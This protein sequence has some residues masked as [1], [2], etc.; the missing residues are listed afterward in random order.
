[1]PPDADRAA[2]AAA[3]ETKS[4]GAGKKRLK[5]LG[6]ILGV[7]LAEGVGIFVLVGV[8][9]APPPATDAAELGQNPEEIIESMDVELALVECDAIN[10]KSGQ[11]VI[12]HIVLCARVAAADRQR[13]GKLI[14]LRQSTIKDRVQMIL[15]SADPQ[16]LNEPNLDTIKRQIK[17][18]VDK[19][20]DDEKL[21]HEILIPQFLQSRSTV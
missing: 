20:L 7:M 11:G 1:M 17:F 15:R 2:D 5:L 13:A 21:I 4:A 12:A 9:S 3:A 6:I 16:H 14:E 19:I 8:T 18:E 10:R